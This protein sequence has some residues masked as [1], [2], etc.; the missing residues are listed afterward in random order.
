MN[1]AIFSNFPAG[2]GK[3]TVF[4][5]TKGLLSLGHQ[6]TAFQLSGPGTKF[7][8]L[9]KL[10]CKVVTIN[11][12]KENSY[13]GFLNRLVADY[14]NF[15]SLRQLHKNLADYINSNFEVALVHTDL[16]TESPFLLR[17]LT[18]PH[19]YHSHELLR[20]GYEKELAFTKKVSLPKKMYELLTRKYRVLIDRQN[21]KAASVIITNSRFS[22]KKIKYA[23]GRDS[24]ICY[25][26]VDTD[27]FRPTV[28]KTKSLVFMGQRNF[29]GGYEFVTQI[30]KLIPKI[31]IRIFGFPEGLPD[32]DSDTLLAKSYSQALATLCVS[33][34]E[35]FGLK[36]LESMSCGTAVLAV[37]EGGY[38]D[39]VVNGKTG[40]LLK[41]DPKLF[42]NEIKKLIRRPK[43]AAQMGKAGRTHV[44]KAWTWKRHITQ[45]NT[46]LSNL[47]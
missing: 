18:I 42:A 15:F 3:R 31:P 32:T 30:Q 14:K 12:T 7:C 45:L 13:P 11:F 2:G 19:V 40:W 33:Y 8:N 29:V 24:I 6:V 9:S 46:I 37:N 35:P 5:Q 4:E 22:K 23:Y 43:L 44:I 21:A 39:S 20:I 1:I 17:F 28:P 41:R 16:Y 34:N 25:S 27:V 26:G 38:E 36:A 47:S 10:N